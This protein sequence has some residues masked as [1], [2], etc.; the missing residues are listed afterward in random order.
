[1]LFTQNLATFF[2]KT[3]NKHVN[4]HLLLVDEQNAKD[5]LFA[6]KLLKPVKSDKKIH[7]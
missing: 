4:T 1:M 7:L 3:S 2:S 6:K 5:E